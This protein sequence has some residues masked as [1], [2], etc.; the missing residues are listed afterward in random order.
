MAWVV[1]VCCYYWSAGLACSLLVGAA[2][3]PGLLH[4]LHVPHINR[5]P[6]PRSRRLRFVHTVALQYARA[7]AFV[8]RAANLA[9]PPL[10]KRNV[11]TAVRSCGPVGASAPN[12]GRRCGSNYAI[13]GCGAVTFAIDLGC[14]K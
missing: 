12:V 14:S 6:Q 10:S 1:A 7:R 3:G 2:G 4:N 13:P 11:L 8:L 5:L 9:S